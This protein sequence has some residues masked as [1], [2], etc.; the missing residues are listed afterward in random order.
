MIYIRPFK[1]EDLDGLDSVEG[2]MAVLSAFDD[3]SAQ[4]IEESGYAATGIRNGKIVCCG[5]IHPMS[6]DHGM[7]WMRLGS[8]CLQ[9]KM[10]S[11]RFVREAL[12]MFEES[13]DFKYLESWIRC[14][15]REAIRL[16]EFLGFRKTRTEESWNIYSKKVEA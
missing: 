13:F 8:D 4:V 1:K 2:D 10:E 12:K 9:Y 6:S 5:G 14:N 16:I 3:D 11:I 7:L 15:F